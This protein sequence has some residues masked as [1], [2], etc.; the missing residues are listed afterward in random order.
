M[1]RYCNCVPL[2]KTAKRTE[3]RKIVRASS[4]EYA[5][6]VFGMFHN[7]TNLDTLGIALISVWRR[8]RE[9]CQEKGTLLKRNETNGCEIPFDVMKIFSRD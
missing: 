7:F 5:F 8:V 3:N 2:Q 1:P 4:E 9:L 6:D